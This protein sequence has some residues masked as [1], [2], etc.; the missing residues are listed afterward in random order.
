MTSRSLR[1]SFPISSASSSVGAWTAS[2]SRN[3]KPSGASEGSFLLSLPLK[4]L[5]RLPCLRNAS[6]TCTVAACPRQHIPPA[7]LTE[8]AFADRLSTLGAIINV[9]TPK[10]EFVS[11]AF[12]DEAKSQ[13]RK[14][15]LR[16][17]PALRFQPVP[18]L[19][20][21]SSQQMARTSLPDDLPGPSLRWRLE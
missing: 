19:I 5:H 9:F 14:V 8:T 16:Y 2:F 17:V 11:V 1:P 21:I 4:Q 3:L 10:F 18:A 13:E 12:P 7:S 20:S 6:G 15:E